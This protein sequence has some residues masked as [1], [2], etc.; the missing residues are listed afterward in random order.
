MVIVLLGLVA[1][2]W[3][4]SPTERRRRGLV[5][6]LEVGDSST[7]VVQTLGSPSARCPGQELSHLQET[8]PPG[9]PAAAVQTTLQELGEQTRERWVYPMNPRRAAGCTPSDGQTEIGV[10][11]EGRVLWIVGVVGKTPLQLPED[12]AP[13]DAQGAAGS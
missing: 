3:V 9:W 1:L 4:V 7:Q 2:V 12:Y 13:A 11:A 6:N 8:F 10:D 5:E